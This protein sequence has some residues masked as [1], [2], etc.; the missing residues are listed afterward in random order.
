LITLSGAGRLDR[1]TIPV[2]ALSRRPSEKRL[3]INYGVEATN[4]LT[5][6]E[7]EYFFSEDPGGKPLYA[8]LVCNHTGSEEQAD[9][10]L[11]QQIEFT[12]EHR[13]ELVESIDE[14]INKSKQNNSTT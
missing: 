12:D 3:D 6:A 9:K 4:K 13:K 2:S 1:V 5:E 11:D 7:E 10:F 14:R 8:H